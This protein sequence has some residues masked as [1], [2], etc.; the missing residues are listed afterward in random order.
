MHYNVVIVI[1]LALRRIRSNGYVQLSTKIDKFF[2]A[3]IDVQLDLEILWFDL[4]FAVQILKLDDAEVRNSNWL[5]RALLVVFFQ[6]SPSF[7]VRY[8]IW[9]Y[10][11]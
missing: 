3:M 9:K 10:S 5:Q 7:D 11:I 2:A 6:L 4:C 8:W 1:R